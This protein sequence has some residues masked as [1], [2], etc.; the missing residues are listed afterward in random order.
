MNHTMMSH[1]VLK[2]AGM[3][4]VGL[5]LVSGCKSEKEEAKKDEPTSPKTTGNTSDKPDTKAPTAKAN[6]EAV[7]RYGKAYPT[8]DETTLRE[9]LHKDVVF[10][11][12]DGLLF[13]SEPQ[14]GIEKDVASA[15][16]W[17]A[18][19]TQIVERDQLVLATPT[20]VAII[21]P[22]KAT[23]KDDNPALAL[24]GK[25]SDIFAAQVFHFDDH[26]KITRGES[27]LDEATLL[28]QLGLRPDEGAPD[29]ANR[30]GDP[31]VVLATESKV[32]KANL[33]TS[34]KL[35][36][37]I[38]K[39]DTDAIATF[40]GEPFTIHDLADP[41]PTKHKTV[42]DFKK[43]YAAQMKQIEIVSREVEERFAAGDWV[44]SKIKA[45]IK[46]RQDLP[47][48]KGSAGKPITRIRFT[49]V[50]F[51]DGRAVEVR[52]IVNDLQIHHQL[53]ALDLEALQARMKPP[54]SDGAK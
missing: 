32:E 15:K 31:Q 12:L 39:G 38:A 2:P 46:L 23:A 10:Q 51:K 43:M 50:R 11:A 19:F 30:W 27:L 49:F 13:G 24:R 52:S 8:A 54:K 16:R 53:D 3:V 17:V 7:A 47:G 5:F 40:T 36:D 28:H 48:V 33:E 29:G 21:F 1:T 26:G 14:S 20:R 37:A 34:N 9:L 4:L 44:F 25:S 41:E 18:G 6:A 22:I 35:A 45:T 42:D